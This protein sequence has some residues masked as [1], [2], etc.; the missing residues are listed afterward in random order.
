[1]SLGSLKVNLNLLH[2]LNISLFKNT[3]IFVF[4]DLVMNGK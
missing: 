4:C 1:M 3:L 2:N